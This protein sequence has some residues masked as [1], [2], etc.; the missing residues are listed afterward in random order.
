MSKLCSAHVNGSRHRLV[1]GGQV[2]VP[3]P[4]PSS[5]IPPSPLLRVSPDGAHGL[6]GVGLLRAPCLPCA[7][8]VKRWQAAIS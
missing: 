4:V 8:L 2:R 5:P 6:P 7:A 1:V 3:V